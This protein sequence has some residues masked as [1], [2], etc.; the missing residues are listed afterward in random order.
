MEAKPTPTANSWLGLIVFLIGVG[1]VI[2]AFKLAYD[3]FTVPPSLA[4]D[5]E[6]GKP[7][8][9]NRSIESTYGVLIKVIVLILMTAFG[10]VVANRGIK[11]YAAKDHA[12]KPSSKKGKQQ[13]V[14]QQEESPEVSE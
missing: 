6:F 2:F 3:L 7:L 11:L 9:I 12:V 5:I 4:L 14:G 1:M 10:S 13:K 8:D